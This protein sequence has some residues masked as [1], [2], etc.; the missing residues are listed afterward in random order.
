MTTAAKLDL[1]N[2]TDLVEKLNEVGDDAAAV[3]KTHQ[4]AARLVVK[5]TRA[6]T[7]S[8]SGDLKKSVRSGYKKDR[9]IVR[10]GSVK[11]P[12]THAYLFGHKDRK[13]GGYMRPHPVPWIALTKVY[14]DVVKLYEKDI[15]DKVK[16][17]I[18]D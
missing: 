12:Y 17:A 15:V 6:E 9:A 10:M 7:R 18:N 2:L 1:H 3:K 5:A 16:D 8:K 14:D 11:V 13:Q 4:K